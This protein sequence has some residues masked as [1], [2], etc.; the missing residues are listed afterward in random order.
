MALDALA[1]ARGERPA[2]ARE[3]QAVRAAIGAAAPLDEAASFQRVDDANHGGTIELHRLG[4]PSLRHARIGLDEKEHSDPT[5]GKLTH[6][7][8]KIAKHRLLRHTQAVADEV[9][10]DALAKGRARG[11]QRGAAC[12]TE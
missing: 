11:F 6:A 2:R 9:G 3:P 7:F 5:G 10:E 12:Y 4:E 8:R 1:Q